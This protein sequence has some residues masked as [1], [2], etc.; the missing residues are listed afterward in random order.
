MNDRFDLHCSSTAS[1][2]VFALSFSHKA[3]IAG[4]NAVV[5]LNVDR[6]SKGDL[7]IHLDP[8]GQSCPGCQKSLQPA[9]YRDALVGELL[10]RL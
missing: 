1:G 7:P 10:S 4:K 2:D 8:C 5:V 6:W 3:K 9:A